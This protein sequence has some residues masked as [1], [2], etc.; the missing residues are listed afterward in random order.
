[1]IIRINEK[2]GIVTL[3]WANNKEIYHFDKISYSEDTMAFIQILG[4]SV[5]IP[6]A[7]GVRIWEDQL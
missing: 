1:M 2:E 6:Y 7:Y 3:E 4:C 5:E